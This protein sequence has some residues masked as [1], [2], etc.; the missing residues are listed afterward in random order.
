M[1]PLA[2]LKVVDFSTTLPGPLAT[3]WLAEAGARVVKVERADGGDPGRHNRPRVGD[4][5]LQFAMLNR[6][7][8]SLAA[9]LKDKAALARVAA[10]VAGADVL[11]EQFRPGVMERLG[12]GYAAMAARNPRLIYCSITGYGQAGPAAQRA[13]H[14]LAYLARNGVLSLGGGTNGEPILP[15]ALIADIGGGTYPAVMNILLAVIER[16]ATGRGRHLDI[17]MAEQ[18]FPWISRQ[19][20][21]T[22]REGAPAPGRSSHTGATPRYGLYRTADGGHVAVAALEEKFWAN[23]CHAIELPPDLRAAG[24][25]AAAV[26][27]GIAARIAA[28]PADDWR[29]AFA[30]D[31]F[32]V[33]VVADLGAAMADPH[34]A[35]RG[36]FARVLR[37]ANGEECPALPVPV[38]RGFLDDAVRSAP[39]LGEL[40]LGE[41]GPDE[42]PWEES[43]S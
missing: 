21:V 38:D 8:R 39:A 40:A 31:D 41:L 18:V 37:L 16:R 42:D 27:A 6:G 25:D 24:A 22:L 29:L 33:E 17:A 43:A 20:A 35:A 23:F 11:V 12:L 26:K 1:Q 34:F 13:G 3:L 36:V 28:R 7:K 19:L 30:G 14:D 5:S 10:L 15:P 9:D 2:G 4:E 32:S